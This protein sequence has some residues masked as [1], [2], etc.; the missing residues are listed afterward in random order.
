MVIAAESSPP[1]YTL[2]ISATNGS[3][4]R[5]PSATIYAP[6][7]EVTLTA[8]PAPGYVFSHWSGDADGSDNPLQVSMTANKAITANFVRQIT[9]PENFTATF[10]I[11][12]NRIQ[13]EWTEV[14]GAETY[15]IWRGLSEALDQAVVVAELTGRSFRDMTAHPGVLYYYWI[16][17]VTGEDRSAFSGPVQMELATGSLVAEYFTG[18]HAM[19]DDWGDGWGQTPW[20]EP[21]YHGEFPWIYSTRFGWLWCAGQG[22]QSLLFYRPGSG[23]TGLPS[24]WIES[25]PAL[26]PHYF[27]YREARWIVFQ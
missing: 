11:Y 9:A 15:E 19:G 17:A 20:F 21:F 16:R 13:L 10:N 3:V 23:D 2:S 14:A 6:G 27:D 8:L 1:G 4:T 7:T 26:Y 24:T 18:Y 12:D 22:G 5:S 25:T